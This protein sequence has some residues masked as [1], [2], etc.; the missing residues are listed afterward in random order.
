[1]PPN[2]SPFGYELTLN[3]PLSS[4]LKFSKYLAFNQYDVPSLG[5]EN[6]NFTT[7]LGKIHHHVQ[8]P[9]RW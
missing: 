9:R 5:K 3:I 6:H 8:V 4:A 7:L 1:M 2:Y